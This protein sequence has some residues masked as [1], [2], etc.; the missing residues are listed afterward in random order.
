MVNRVGTLVVLI[1]L[2]AGCKPEAGSSRPNSASQPY[3]TISSR[4][5]AAQEASAPSRD[6]F[7]SVERGIPYSNLR[8]DPSIALTIESFDT[9]GEYGT[10]MV[11]VQNRG[12]QTIRIHRYV[13]STAV[14]HARVTAGDREFG[15]VWD[16]G[17]H[18]CPGPL[19]GEFAPIEPGSTVSLQLGLHSTCGIQPIDGKPVNPWPERFSVLASGM[20]PVT[21]ADLSNLRDVAVVWRGDVVIKH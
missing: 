17:T 21:D 7:R 1:L 3:S 16:N 15:F 14:A 13:L 4:R 6:K 20:V 8:P 19:E 10:A 18:F 12:T 9:T 5:A 11:E 2:A